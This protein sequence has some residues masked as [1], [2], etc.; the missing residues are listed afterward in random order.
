MVEPD[1]VSEDQLRVELSWGSVP[2]GTAQ[3]GMVKDF[4]CL[5]APGADFG[6]MGVLPPLMVGKITFWA[7]IW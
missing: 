4:S 1:I 5:V 3:N 6:E 7:P 2:H